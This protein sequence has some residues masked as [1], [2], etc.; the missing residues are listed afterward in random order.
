MA[1]LVVLLALA[2]AASASGITVQ[3]RTVDHEALA[4]PGIEVIATEVSECRSRTQTSSVVVKSTTGGEGLV[5]LVLPRAHAYVIR[6]TGDAGF[7]AADACVPNLDGTEPRYVQLQLRLD[8]RNTVTIEEPSIGPAERRTAFVLSDF[9][10]VYIGRGGS[11]VVELDVSGD[12]LNVEMPDRHV[13]RFSRRTGNSFDGPDGTI[14]FA[15]DRARV[16]GFDLV[17]IAVHATRHR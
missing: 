15:I 4:L 13:R 1:L 2:Q 9:L 11:F 8:P 5:S 14:R 12:G 6:S 7:E 17:P 3:V 10:G 16:V